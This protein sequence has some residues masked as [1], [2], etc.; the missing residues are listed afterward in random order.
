MTTNYSHGRP[1]RFVALASTC[2]SQRHPSLLR[3]LSQVLT[4]QKIENECSLA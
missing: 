3:L 2:G 1:G 4:A